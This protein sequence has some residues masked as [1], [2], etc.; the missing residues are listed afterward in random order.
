MTESQI[1]QTYSDNALAGIIRQL[2]V[3]EEWPKRRQAAIREQAKRKL[4][5]QKQDQP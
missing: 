1:V 3:S 4:Q 2:T 5:N